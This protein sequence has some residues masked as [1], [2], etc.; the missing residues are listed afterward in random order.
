MSLG[1]A[2]K[3]SSSSLLK[4]TS[5][6]PGGT[7]IIE[8][9]RVASRKRDR[10]CTVSASVD[11][12]DALCN[13]LCDGPDEPDERDMEAK[14]WKEK[15][16]RLNEQRSREYIELSHRLGLT[17]EREKKLEEHAKVLMSK[18]KLTEKR[19]SHPSHQADTTYPECHRQKLMEIFQHLTSITVESEELID[20]YEIYTC[21]ITNARLL[22][23]ARFQIRLAGKESHW[24][25]VS[26]T[27]LFPAYLKDHISFE[28][29]M[30][31]VILGDVLQN[32][33][34]E[35]KD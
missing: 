7:L 29:Q 17:S 23:T 11:D 18:L 2:I 27:S 10:I 33:Y 26:N 20:G 6:S 14:F 21:S 28:E 15:F 31:P 24:L 25:P 32:L 16:V 30:L 22:K 3:A 19:L 34:E 12:T 8:K 1:S 4:D 35:E 9:A 13:R 5:S